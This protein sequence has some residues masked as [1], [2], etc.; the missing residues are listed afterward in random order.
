MPGLV[1]PAVLNKNFGLGSG[2]QVT[3]FPQPELKATCWDYTYD[4]SWDPYDDAY[5]DLDD[6]PYIE[7][8]TLT[9]LSAEAIYFTFGSNTE[10]NDLI[11]LSDLLGDDLVLGTSFTKTNFWD[12][13][14]HVA[15]Q[16]SVLLTSFS[17]SNTTAPEMAVLL[18]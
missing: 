17:W 14:N 6:S 16:H 5:D 15:Q 10:L 9:F 18:T 13:P 2:D 3:V 4:P 12:V 1:M 8:N 11:T 7:N